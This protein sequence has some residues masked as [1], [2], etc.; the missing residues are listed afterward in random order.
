[1]LL[2]NSP[3]MLAVQDAVPGAGC[4]TLIFKLNCAALVSRLHSFAVHLLCGDLEWR[5][6]SS[7]GRPAGLQPNL[8]VIKA[9]FQL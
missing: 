3:V 8:E 5:R 6:A 1:M 7:S 9:I 2:N 4:V